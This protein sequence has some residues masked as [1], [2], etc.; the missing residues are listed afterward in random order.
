VKFIAPDLSSIQ[1]HIVGIRPY[2]TGGIRVERE[3]IG[4]KLIIH[5]YGHGGSG[6]TLSWGTVQ[7]ALGLCKDQLNRIKQNGESIAIL[8]AGIIG[9]TTAYLLLQNGYQVRIYATQI[10]PHTTSDVAAALWG[11]FGLDISQEPGA[12]ERF[13]NWQKESFK[14][15]KIF[16]ENSDLFPGVSFITTYYCKTPG[17]YPHRNFLP[18]LIPPISVEHI[19]GKDFWVFQDL[20][21]EIPVYME[22]LHN[23]VAQL[24]AEIVPCILDK[25]KIQQLPEQIIFNCTGLGSRELFDDSALVPIRGQL[26]TVAQKNFPNIVLIQR[27][28]DNQN[29]FTI[30]PRPSKKQCIIGVTYEF[31]VE[32]YEIDFDVSKNLLDAAKAFFNGTL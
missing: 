22:F 23:Q 25:Q 31:G 24:G 8:G 15:F 12:P 27:Y 11:P 21:I 17:A 1:E 13:D 19:D 10:S 30:I 28:N 7:D 29:I 16:A 4:S 18:D 6:I 3:Q 26:V 32:N 20:F 5:N 9:L 2:R 14:Q